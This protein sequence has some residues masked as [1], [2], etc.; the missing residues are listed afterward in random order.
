LNK[1]IKPKSFS[2]VQLRNK[3]AQALE[4]TEERIAS[5][6]SDNP[7][8]VK[9]KHEAEGRKAV[10]EAMWEALHGDFTLLNCMLPTAN[11][12]SIQMFGERHASS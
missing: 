2:I 7:Q 9:M 1:S 4:I 8:I 3:V 6:G 12:I 5:F 10:L 11:E